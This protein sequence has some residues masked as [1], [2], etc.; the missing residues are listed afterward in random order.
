MDI[1]DAQLVVSDWLSSEQSYQLAKNQITHQAKAYESLHY[2]VEQEM[3]N[4]WHRYSLAR[5][6]VRSG[7]AEM[8]DEANH[9]L[10]KVVST[11][12]G[13]AIWGSVLAGDH[14]DR[15]LSST[16]QSLDEYESS[17]VTGHTN[18]PLINLLDSVKPPIPIEVPVNNEENITRFLMLSGLAVRSLWEQSQENGTIDVPKTKQL[19]PI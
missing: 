19:L 15:A 17:I 3:P 13:A 14:L 11:A 6:A 2:I 4:K 18:L 8:T 1:P 5:Q 12:R 16:W 9:R 10:M 7:I